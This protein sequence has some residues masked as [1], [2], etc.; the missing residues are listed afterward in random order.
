MTDALEIYDKAIAA[1]PGVTRKG[2]KNKYT[3]HQGHMFSFLDGD[4]ICVRLSPE[5]KRAFEAEHGPQEVRQYG[6][7]MRG[8]VEAPQAMMQ[9]VA[10]LSGLLGQGL[11]YVSS[12][13]PK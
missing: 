5:D 6:S 8:Y 11:A 7:V 2:A 9:D 4:R 1:L 13:K 10:A 12:L 3:S